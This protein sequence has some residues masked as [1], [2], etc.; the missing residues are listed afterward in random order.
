MPTASHIERFTGLP[1]HDLQ[2]GLTLV[3]A[4]T[5]K[6]RRRGLAGLDSLPAEH[7][8]LIP[9]CPAIHTFGMRIALDLIWLGKGDAVVRV[10]RNVPPNRMRAC[11]R[12]RSVV[13][14]LAGQADAFLS[15]GV[16][17]RRSDEADGDRGA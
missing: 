13:E 4:S 16:G 12:A 11:P 3:E 1:R 6:A 2:G 8:L 17:T 14:T 10:D 7:A 15:V 9:R 5:R